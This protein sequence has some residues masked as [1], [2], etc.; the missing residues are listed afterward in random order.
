MVPYRIPSQLLVAL[1]SRTAVAFTRSPPVPNHRRTTVGWVA[2]FLIGSLLGGILTAIIVHAVSAVLLSSHCTPFVLPPPPPSPAVATTTF[3]S[4][5]AFIPTTAA[6]AA[7]STAPAGVSMP[8]SAS[9][10]AANVAADA[11]AAD[12]AADVDAASNAT[13]RGDVAGVQAEAE[14][15]LVRNTE[16]RRALGKLRQTV[17]LEARTR[18][19]QLKSIL[20]EI[21]LV[22]DQRVLTFYVDDRHLPS[23]PPE[24]REIAALT[25][26]RRPDVDAK[27]EELVVRAQV[28]VLSLREEIERAVHADLRFSFSRCAA[29]LQH[30]QEAQ[31]AHTQ[32]MQ[33]Y[34]AAH[35]TLALR[36]TALSVLKQ[37]GSVEKLQRLKEQPNLLSSPA[38]R[39]AFLSSL[40][41]L[42]LKQPGSAEKLQQLREQPS[43]LSSPAARNTFFSSLD[44]PAEVS[45]WADILFSASHFSSVFLSADLHPPVKHPLIPLCF[46]PPI[47]FC[48]PPPR[49]SSRSITV[50]RPSLLCIPFPLHIP[51]Y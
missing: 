10:D 40:D 38:A 29:A 32:A 9:A 14:E 25:A 1:P 42:V 46:L 28:R 20:K 27:E 6:T 4:P 12:V 13:W 11:V 49:V 45:L 26:R 37:P 34:M 44:A 22:Q 31:Q 21:K 39:N 35:A 2:S 43:L 41:P 36:L 15:L 3:S 8:M 47:P 33:A 23:P 30:T 16:L 19:A 17:M 5:I 7:T 18:M 48:H 51:L 24:L 50:V